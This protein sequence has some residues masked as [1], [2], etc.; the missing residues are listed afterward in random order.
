MRNGYRFPTSNIVTMS[1]VLAVILYILARTGML[2]SVGG[3]M[4]T[5]FA[6]TAVVAL[7]IWSVL[8]ATHRSGSHRLADARTRRED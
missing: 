3:W 2:V 4:I 7:A 6:I 5:M 1:L 8:V